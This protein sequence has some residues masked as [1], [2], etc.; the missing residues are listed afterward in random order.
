[1]G[2]WPDEIL[3]G[4][5]LMNQKFPRY[6]ALPNITSS[7]EVQ[8]FFK[9]Q[10]VWSPDVFL[11]GHQTFNTFK[12]RKEIQFFLSNFFFQIFSFKF[13]LSKISLVGI[14]FWHQISIQGPYLTSIDNQ[15]LVGKMFK[16][17]SW[18][19]VRSGKTC[20]AKL[21]VR[22]CLVRKLICPV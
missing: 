16:N 4:Q 7:P 20:S 10:T 2:A 19:S 11:P 17:I 21:V 8:Q 18:D 22:S 15:Y 9:I 6:R 5:R 3:S 1:M 12:N 13:F 14:Y